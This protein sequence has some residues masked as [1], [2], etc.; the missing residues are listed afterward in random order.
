MMWP[1][2]K[3]KTLLFDHFLENYFLSKKLSNNYASFWKNHVIIFKLDAMS[4]QN[5]PTAD[6]LIP[7]FDQ[8]KLLNL[9]IE[10]RTNF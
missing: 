1:N 5:F 8:K 10:L 4:L 3:V 2:L 9:K 6:N 7:K